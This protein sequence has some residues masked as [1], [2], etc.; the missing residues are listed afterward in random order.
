MDK[1]S[2]FFEKIDDFC[3]LARCYRPLTGAKK[4]RAIGLYRHLRNYRQTVHELRR[5]KIF[6]SVSGLRKMVI[7]ARETGSVS[8]RPRS[9]RPRKTG[10]QED[11]VLR[12]IAQRNRQKSLPSLAESFAL[13]SGTRLSSNTI[14]RRLKEAGLARRV[15]TQVPLLK[16]AQ[17]EK[18]LA[19]ATK[20]TKARRSFWYRVIFTD[21]KMEVSG[22]Q[23][24]RPLVTRKTSERFSPKCMVSR[25]KRPVQVHFWGAISKD[26]VGPIRRIEG[27]LNAQK[28][29]QDI[30]FDVDDLCNVDPLHPRKSRIFQQDNAPAHSARSTLAFLSEKRVPVLPWPGNSPD[31][32]PIE[33]VWA[34]LSRRVRARG[35]AGSKDQL[36]EWIQEEWDRTPITLIHCLYDSMPARIQ[37]AI[38]NKGGPTHY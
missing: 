27:N 35:M 7:R 20:Y 6:L 4:E 5:Q 12:R 3:L 25:V 14:S 10:R 32:N 1:N 18:R 11:A 9:G 16:P 30:L 23:P 22:G 17:R 28:Y 13:D 24:T 38:K 36:W 33:H 2:N 19:F 34:D 37:E 26:G 21:E 31:F 29:Q 15:A 8:P